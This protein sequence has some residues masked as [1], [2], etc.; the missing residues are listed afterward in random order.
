MA[1]QEFELKGKIEQ[2][3]SNENHR[4]FTGAT[5]KEHLGQ[6]TDMT[7]E[8][9]VRNGTDITALIGQDMSI[10]TKTRADKNRTF[11]GIVV[12]LEEI[13]QRK[14][15]EGLDFHYVAIVRPWLWMLTRAT[16]NR[17]FQEKT[18]VQIIEKVFGDHGFS[19]YDKKLNQ[20]FESRDY[21]VQYRETDFDFVSRLME[22]EGIYY[23]FDTA[24]DANASSKLVLCDNTGAHAATPGLP[25]VSFVGSGGRGVG[26]APDAATDVSSRIRI[27]T[28]MITL[29]DYDMLTPTAD[30]KVVKNTIVQSSHSHGAYEN[31]HY[32][33]K[34]RQ[35][36]GRGNRLAEIRMQAK[37]VENTS[38]GGATTSRAVSVGYKFDLKDNVASGSG[39]SGDFGPR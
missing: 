38:Y 29:N 2:L 11:A 12:G 34:Y 37:E 10:S 24:P 13:G 17:I 18:A 1:D 14:S 15:E 16:N 19:D 5:I 26:G 35:V 20:T 7:V 30:L 39:S 8:F 3:V 33:A 28:G 4:W 31:Y 21:C 23:Y 27:T 22:E 6:I 36:T 9:V 32:P 25:E